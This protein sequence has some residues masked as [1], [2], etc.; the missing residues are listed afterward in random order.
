MNCHV[1]GKEKALSYAAGY[2]C[3]RETSDCYYLRP[4]VPWYPKQDPTGPPVWVQFARG[5][6]VRFHPY[7]RQDL[8]VWRLR[9]V[10]REEFEAMFRKEPPTRYEFLMSGP[11]TWRA[12][13]L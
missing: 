8:V 12:G 13:R 11:Q 2:F 7:Y 4:A 1:C 9:E 10:T 6:L 5:N 3:D